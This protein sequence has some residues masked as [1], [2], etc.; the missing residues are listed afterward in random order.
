MITSSKFT[1]LELYCLSLAVSIFSVLPAWSSEESDWLESLSG[2]ESATPPVTNVHQPAATN[3][4]SPAASNIQTSSSPRT[5]TD[6][7]AKTPIDNSK[8]ETISELL[9]KSSRNG[10]QLRAHA[11]LNLRNGN[12]DQ[13]IKLLEQ[14][15]ELDAFDLD[16]RHAYA[17]ALEKKLAKEKTRDPHLYNLCVKQWFYL[18]KNTDFMED[19]S[20]ASRHLKDL[21]GLAPKVFY[22]AKSYLAKVLLPECDEEQSGLEISARESGL[23]LEADNSPALNE[24][25]QV[26]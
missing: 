10:R 16:N 1:P 18:Y 14:A 11:D 17:E 2:K 22:S 6:N 9:T 3:A 24:P 23:T 15:I 19:S 21:T 13:A 8:L 25:L 20:L 26:P 7:S 5:A 4:S 12:I